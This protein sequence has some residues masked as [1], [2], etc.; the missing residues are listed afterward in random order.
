MG[1]ERGRGLPVEMLQ[2]LRFPTA[3]LNCSLP[4]NAHEAMPS[5][6]N[7]GQLC[8]SRIVLSSKLVVMRSTAKKIIAFAKPEGSNE[9]WKIRCEMVY[10]EPNRPVAVLEWGTDMELL[11]ARVVAVNPELLFASTQ[12]HIEFEYRNNALPILIPKDLIAAPSELTTVAIHRG[13][14]RIA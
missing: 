5:T 9:V 6:P 1:R 8:L 2:F 4:F 14:S 11:G 10:S 7:C 13:F 12:P 3:S